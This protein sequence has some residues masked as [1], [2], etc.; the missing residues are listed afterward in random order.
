[1]TYEL[2]C[3][4]G[5]SD[6]VPTQHVWIGSCMPSGHQ[7]R[8]LLLANSEFTIAGTHRYD[9]RSPVRWVVSH[10]IRYPWLPVVV[11]L[12]GIAEAGLFSVAPVLIGQAFDLMNSAQRS[13]Q[14]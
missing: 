8:R 12:T 5:R 4:R 2:H 9:Y 7:I 1:M 10:L 13:A 3:V 11:I 14:A 6:D